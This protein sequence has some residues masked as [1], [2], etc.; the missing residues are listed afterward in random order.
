[1]GLIVVSYTLKDIRDDEGY[2]KALGMSRT[3]QVSLQYYT[4]YISLSAQTA[5]R[6]KLVAPSD[7]SYSYDTHIYTQIIRLRV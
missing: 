4:V 1:M 7:Q 3:A 5:S 2:L 6:D